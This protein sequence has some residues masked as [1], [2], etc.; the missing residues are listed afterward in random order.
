MQVIS[1]LFDSHAQAAEAADALRE[2]GVAYDDISIVGP[3]EEEDA[4]TAEDVGVGAAV[5]G[6]GG[7][8]AGLATFAVPGVGPVLGVGWLAATLIGATAGGVAGGLL[9]GLKDSGVSDEDAHVYAE[10]IKRGSVLVTA[11]V[12]ETQADAA[13][14]ILSSAGSADLAA[15]RSEYE[16][17]GWTSFD[18]TVENDPVSAYDEHKEST[19]LPP[20]P[21]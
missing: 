9:G 13:Q 14:A 17:A 15:R 18:E 16:S 6:A 1:G 7:L 12:D 10:G 20:L 19:I 21:R 8:L 3:D 5:G 11:R 4:T 2:A